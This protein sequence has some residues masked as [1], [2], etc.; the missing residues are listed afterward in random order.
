MIDAEHSFLQPAIDLA[1]AELQAA[2][3]R[4]G[5]PPVVYGT[6]Q[7]YLAD[8]LPRL[9]TDLERAEHGGYSLG[10]KVVRGAYMV[11]ER[12]RAAERGYP[13]PVLPTKAATDESYDRWGWG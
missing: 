1:T 3:N 4:R 12:R 11:L 2:H 8:A 10:A 5:A 13:C 6:Y 7:A 9:R